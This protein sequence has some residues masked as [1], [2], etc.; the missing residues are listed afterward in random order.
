[1]NE[2]IQQIRLIHLTLLALSFSLLVISF[3]RDPTDYEKA[4]T[5]AT[6]I[7]SSLHSWDPRFLDA[8]ALS[9]LTKLG[10][11][12]NFRAD[13]II[14]TS[15]APHGQI[16]FRYA[17][18]AW[19][20]HPLPKQLRE[21]D[22]S[23]VERQVRYTGYIQVKN[24][25]LAGQT[26]LPAPTTLSDFS[27]TWNALGITIQVFKPVDIG[28]SGYIHWVFENKAPAW[29]TLQITKSGTAADPAIKQML[30]RAPTEY[31]VT[32]FSSHK[33]FAQ[34]NHT[35]MFTGGLARASDP[36]SQVEI[37]LPVLTETVRTFNGQAALVSQLHQNWPLQ[38]FGDAFPEL[39]SLTKGFEELPLDQIVKVLATLAK[40]PS[41]QLEVFGTKLPTGNVIAL[42]VPLILGVQLYLL[43]HLHALV[44]VVLSTSKHEEFSSW[45]GLFRS[46]PAQLVS[47]ITAF[48]VTPATIGWVAMS[49]LRLDSPWSSLLLVAATISIALGA[50]GFVS[51]QRTRRALRAPP[52]TTASHP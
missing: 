30:F 1:M 51:L 17:E 26:F 22:Q 46:W 31:E 40:R 27:E 43:L 47:N 33:E 34:A 50:L 36:K 10:I 39:A 42:L 44:G 23:F 14:A 3:E 41:K 38:A 28:A 6:S 29:K 19:T 21:R 24:D 32:F 7:A 9:E 18:R 2:I 48:V 35:H 49:E 45:I 37:E 15:I 8:H 52:A 4:L 5:Q 12:E 25:Y 13:A 16:K 11:P 20:L